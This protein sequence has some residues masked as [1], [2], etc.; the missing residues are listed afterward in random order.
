MSLGYIPKA[1]R[2]IRTHKKGYE[3]GTTGTYIS[4]SQ[5]HKNNISSSGEFPILLY[6]M[7]GPPKRFIRIKPL[8]F[9]HIFVY[10]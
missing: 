5:K 9:F 2:V 7:S 4:S 1:K 10:V 3:R 8:A 6:F